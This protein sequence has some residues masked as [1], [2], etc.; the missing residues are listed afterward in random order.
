MYWGLIAPGLKLTV[1]LIVGLEPTSYN[2]D[3]GLIVNDE[4]LGF[5][6]TGFNVG[7]KIHWSIVVIPLP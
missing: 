7:T 1:P 4:I 5:V 2:N 3:V 6:K